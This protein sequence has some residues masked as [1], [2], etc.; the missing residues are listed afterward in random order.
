MLNQKFT[1]RRGQGA[2]NH[3]RKICVSGETQLDR[4][5]ITTEFGTSRNEDKLKI[6]NENFGKLSRAARGYGFVIHCNNF[7]S[8]NKNNIV[9]ESEHLVPLHSTWQWYYIFLLAG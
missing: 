5:L 3:N 7:Q 9:T 1:A 6:V 2:F 4:A 8:D